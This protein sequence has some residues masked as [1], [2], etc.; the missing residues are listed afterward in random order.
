MPIDALRIVLPKPSFKEAIYL[1]LVPLMRKGYVQKAGDGECINLRA[2]GKSSYECDHDGQAIWRIPFHTWNGGLYKVAFKGSISRTAY[3]SCWD[4]EGLELTEYRSLISPSNSDI[5]SVYS[6]PDNGSAFGIIFPDCKKGD[7]LSIEDISVQKIRHTKVFLSSKEIS[8]RKLFRP[9][10]LNIKRNCIYTVSIHYRHRHLSDNK[11]YI[12]GRDK[13]TGKRMFK[14]FLSPKSRMSSVV[15]DSEDSDSISV[16]LANQGN[17]G[18]TKSQVAICAL[19]VKQEYPPF[20]AP[21]PP[22]RKKGDNLVGVSIATY[23]MRR[24]IIGPTIASLKDQCDV[25][26]LYLNN[27]DAIPDEIMDALGGKPHEIVIDPMSAKRASAKLHW[28]YVPG[29]HIICDD[30]IIYPKDYVSHMI[31]KINQYEKKAFVGVHAVIFEEFIKDSK[32]SRK[33]IF[34]ARRA[35]SEDTPVH[36]I[37]TGTLAYHSETSQHVPIKDIERV[38]YSI[39]ETFAVIAKR[40]SVP[41]IAVQRDDNWLVGNP[42]M[43]YGLHEEK[44][45]DASRRKEITRML[46]ELEPWISPSLFETNKT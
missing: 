16:G 29:Y 31:E 32:N 25:I 11:I 19:T 41:L 13:K 2:C 12:E 44:L 20:K 5:S 15:F 43:K 22:Y 26:R 45:Q 4:K 37:G 35:L 21:T 30:D 1:A 3:L 24:E 14:R 17:P 10:E 6:T 18:S 46:K 7:T 28:A 23:P 8:S 39:D 38:P 9:F 27:Y 34:D 40:S 36:L 42:L 33:H